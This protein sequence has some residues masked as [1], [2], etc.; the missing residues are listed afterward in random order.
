MAKI[1]D[2]ALTQ[3]VLHPLQNSVADL[4]RVYR[5]SGLTY[6]PFLYGKG[7]VNTPSTIGLACTSE[8]NFLITRTNFGLTRTSLC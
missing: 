2:R 1:A 4:G 5:E 7:S 6:T 3:L 8:Y